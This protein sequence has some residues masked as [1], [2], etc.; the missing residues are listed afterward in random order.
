MYQTI[1]DYLRQHR[2]KHV[3]IKASAVNPGG[4]TT[5]KHLLA[6]ELRGVV[7]AAAV[8]GGSIVHVVKKQSISKT[9]GSRT[10]DEYVKD[11][12]FW[13]SSVSGVPLRVGSR[14]A[15]LWA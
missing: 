11:N 13:T 10:A 3:A 8:D 1:S 14:E 2:V 4:G 7:A 9:F 6:A 12:A 5:N 15:A